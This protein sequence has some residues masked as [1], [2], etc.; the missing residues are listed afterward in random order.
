MTTYLER[1]SPWCLVRLLPKMQRLT[2]GR[3]RRW[4]D[5]HEHMRC[6][7]SEDR[8]SH[9]LGQANAKDFS[10]PPLISRRS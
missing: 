7:C 6:S 8:R 5:A 2:V 10:F 4:N 1:L 9:E 3:F